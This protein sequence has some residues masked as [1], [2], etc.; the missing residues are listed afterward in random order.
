ML[1]VVNGQGYNSVYTTMYALIED[2]YVDGS[3]GTMRF[4]AMQVEIRGRAR[5]QG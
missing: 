2:K 5:S 1:K 4:E 3:G